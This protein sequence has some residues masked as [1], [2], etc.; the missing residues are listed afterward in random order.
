MDSKLFDFLILSF[1]LNLLVYSGMSFYKWDL[2]WLDF[3]NWTT[4]ERKAFVGYVFFSVDNTFYP[5]K[6]R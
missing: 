3:W 4:E 2:L 1:S 5:C 6:F